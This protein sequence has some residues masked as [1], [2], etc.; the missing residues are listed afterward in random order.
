MTDDSGQAVSLPAPAARVVSLAPHLTEIAFA[1]G[2]GSAVKAVIRYS[3]YP[4]A[5][6]E[7]PLVGDAFALDLET[8]VRLKPDLVLV[9]TSG[10][11]ERHRARLRALG[12]TIYESEIRNAA[13]I[14]DTMRRL[15]IVARTCARSR[16][17]RTSLRKRLAISARSLPR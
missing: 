12:L 14:A 17:R 3:D 1:A 16:R 11:N 2:G 10:L 8:I 9:W 7:L 13:A 4:A 6:R 5:A 15:G